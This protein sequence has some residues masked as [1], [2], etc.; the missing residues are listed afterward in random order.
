MIARDSTWFSS[1]TTT[2]SIFANKNPLVFEWPT[3]FKPILLI[4]ARNP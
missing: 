3:Q 2:S 1:S 4:L